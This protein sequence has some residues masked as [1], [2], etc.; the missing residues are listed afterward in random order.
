MLRAFRHRNYQL[1][2]AGQLISVCGTWMQAVAQS[3]LIYRLTGSAMLLGVVG[4]SAQIPVFLLSPVGGAIADRFDRRRVVIATQATA[5]ILALILAALT[6]SGQVRVWHLPVLAALLGIVNAFDVPARQAFV[7]EMTGK[8]DLLNAIAL[9][10]SMF[11]SARIIGPAIAGVLV[12]TIGEGWCFFANGASYIAVIASLLMMRLEARPT[13]KPLESAVAGIVGGFV[14]AW[15]NRTVRAV[16]LL[17]ALASLLGMPYG[18][19]LP[20]FAREVLHGGPEAFGLLVGSAG[21]GA[22]VGALTLAAR[23]GTHGLE[24]WIAFSSAGFGVSLMLFSVSRHFWLST[25][26]LLPVGFCVI[27]QMASANTLIQTIVPDDL[28]G[29][30]MA[31]YSMMFI[32]MGPFGALLAGG[33]A[34]Q[35]GAPIT[36]MLGGMACVIGAVIFGVNLR[37]VRH[38][39]SEMIVAAEMAPGNPPDEETGRGAA[40][41]PRD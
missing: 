21:V 11:N 27:G 35:F 19:L 1:F 8:D 20:I 16:L 37:T 2:F 3:W 14:F 38:G 28:R 40:L 26:L 24:R 23:R 13:L 39:A 9:N 36:V 6:L 31:V 32:G 30:I 10:S 17:V 33:V 29:R 4:F 7:V 22:L 15:R 5:M 34:H 25:A 41:V 18:V 12:A